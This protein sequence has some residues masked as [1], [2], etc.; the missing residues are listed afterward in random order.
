MISETIS[1]ELL[2]CLACWASPCPL[3]P[4]GEIESGNE[5]LCLLLEIIWGGAVPVQRTE[6]GLGT[7]DRGRS[8]ALSSRREDVF[9]RSQWMA[10]TRARGM[11]YVPVASLG[12]QRS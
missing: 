12:P 4:L 11:V 6:G 8:G 3:W 10:E 7:E 5:L 2:A 9:Q 1:F